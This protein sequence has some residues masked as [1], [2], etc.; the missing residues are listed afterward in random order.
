VT[1][2]SLLLGLLVGAVVLA[3]GS[4]RPRLP[5]ALRA[6]GNAPARPTGSPHA[7]SPAEPGWSR[8]AAATGAAVMVWVVVGGT[9]GLLLGGGTGVGTWLV[10]GRME[11]PSVRR[12][13]ER[14]EADLPHAVDLMAACLAGGQ[15]P[16]AAVAHIAASVPAPMSD[17]LALVGARVRLG[18]DPVTVW[19]DLGRHPQLGP[20]G[21]AVAR[22]LDS[23]ASVA[24][25]MARLAEELRREA[26]AGVE[27]RARSV[28]VKAAL[29]LGVCLLPAFVLVGV[30]PLVV[31]SLDSLLTP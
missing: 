6:G 10:L 25:A 5:T 31:G 4:P 15:A 1:P 19:R 8:A 18:L 29:P 11:H 14:L 24:E 21:R 27:A 13:R 20:L 26:R 16:G 7:T 3:A 2:S 9:A 17:E 22:A 28:G 12:R 23:G 30:V